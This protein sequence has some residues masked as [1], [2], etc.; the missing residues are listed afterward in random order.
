M[1]L[2]VIGG[3]NFVGRF[4]LSSLASSYPELRLGD[5]YPYRSS[6]YRLQEALGS[7]KVTKHALSHPTSLKL[8]LTGASHAV[9]VTHDYFKLAHSKNFLL[10]K[11]AF[12]AKDLG[13]PKLTVVAPLELTQLNP[14]D[15][16]PAKLVS[17]S[18]AKAK[19]HYPGLSILRTNLIFGQNCQSLLIQHALDRLCIGKAPVYARDGIS[20]FQPVHES[21][22]LSAF[23]ALQ[24]GQDVTLA[25]PE[26]LSWAEVVA[27]LKKH[28]NAGDVSVGGALE[29]LRS[30][31]AT[32]SLFGD[33]LWPSQLQQLYRLLEKDQVPAPTKTG[34]KKLAEVY[35]PSAYAPVLP[36]AWHRVILD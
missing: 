2:T 21:D 15:G 24:P 35:T 25:G 30:A 26:V 28:A 1:A 4:L 32:N 27:V 16:D 19:S 5:M 14:L 8:A 7:V 31:I 20:K 33:L 11:T 18:E 17:A 34:V 22:L 9:V 29:S 12:M 13:V 10:E 23:L 3:S 36:K 6:V